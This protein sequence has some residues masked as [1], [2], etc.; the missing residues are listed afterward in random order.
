MLSLKRMIGNIR[1]KKILGIG[2]GEGYFSRFYAESG[3]EV[4][5]IDFS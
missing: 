3:I 1:G 4:V 2:C 5:G